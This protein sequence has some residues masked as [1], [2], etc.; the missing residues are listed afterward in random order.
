M[1]GMGHLQPSSSIAFDVSSPSDT[2]R[3]LGLSVTEA[4]CQ[5]TKSLRSSPLRGGVSRDAGDKP[6][7]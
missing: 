7:G 3:V 5:S 2:F 1:A 6:R 4:L